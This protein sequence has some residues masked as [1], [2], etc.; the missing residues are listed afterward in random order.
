MIPDREVD[1]SDEDDALSSLIQGLGSLEIKPQ[2]KLPPKHTVVLAVGLSERVSSLS[3]GLAK[4]TT[5]SHL[6][7]QPMHSSQCE[8]S[9]NNKF[10]KWRPICRAISEVESLPS[11]S[12]ED[13]TVTLNTRS[14]GE[15]EAGPTTPFSVRSASHASEQSRAPKWKPIGLQHLTTHVI[16]TEHNH[17][18]VELGK[19]T[20]GVGEVGS[21]ASSDK[22]NVVPDCDIPDGPGSRNAVEDTTKPD[23]PSYKPPATFM[24]RS[25]RLKAKSYAH[26]ASAAVKAT[27]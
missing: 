17:S 9:R 27:K 10:S 13:S 11:A 1:N 18:P 26:I 2:S 12:L 15:A 3:L 14:N 16:S 24:P 23:A 8:A 20:A 22:E 19:V 5:E 25:I 21:K 6:G 4:A 7:E